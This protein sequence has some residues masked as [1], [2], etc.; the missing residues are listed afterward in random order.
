MLFAASILRILP[1]VGVPFALIVLNLFGLIVTVL[2]L[3]MMFKAY[4]GGSLDLPFVRRF[5][6]LKTWPVMY[7]CRAGLGTSRG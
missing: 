4:R 7:A 3:V 1:W 2:W 5:W 6:L